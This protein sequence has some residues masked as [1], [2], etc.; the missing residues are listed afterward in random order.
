[1]PDSFKHDSERSKDSSAASKAAYEIK[2]QNIIA[3]FMNPGCE[4]EWIMLADNLQTLSS[5]GKTIWRCN[6]CAEITNTYNWQT[7]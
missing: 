7:P 2:S 5:E 1:M 6:T 3:G 4:H